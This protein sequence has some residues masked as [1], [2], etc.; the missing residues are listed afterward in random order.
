MMVPSPDNS[1]WNGDKG[2]GGISWVERSRMGPLRG[3][4]DAADAKGRR[5]EYM[6]R[7]HLRVLERELRETGSLKNAL[8]FGCGTGRF[9]KTLATH[10]DR[11]WATDKETAMLEA[12]RRYSSECN[13]EIAQCDPAK[14]P[15]DN[16]QFDFVL[17]SSVLCV[18]LQDLVED[19]LKELARVTKAGGRLLLL[20]Q[21]AQ[22]RGLGASRYY[23]ALAAA[24][25]KLVRAYPIR[26]ADS[27]ITVTVA[28]NSL[29]PRQLFDSLAAMELFITR[30]KPGRQS[31]RYIEYAIVSTRD[32]GGGAE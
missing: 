12:A 25:F 22:A 7:L 11:V 8:D 32:A 19:I 3:V 16:A 2:A 21:V 28:R 31:S 20:E 9:I 26:A 23:E 15:F 30:F 24:E 4:I 5:N 13:V 10:C 1:L 14:L 27:K 6:H 18:T 29:I 17:C